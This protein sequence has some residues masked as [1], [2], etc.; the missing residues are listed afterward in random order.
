[1]KKLVVLFN[2]CLMLNL[3]GANA[4]VVNSNSQTLSKI[5]LETGY[6]NNAFS[7]I[8]LYANRVILSEDFIYVVNSGDNSV[9][10]IDLN[11]GETLANIPVENSSNPYDMIIHNGFAFVTG[12]F[13]S[14]VYKID[15]ST[16]QV[17]D[18]IM[19]GNSPEG[20]VVY[21]GKLYVANTNYIY[22][23][24]NPGTVSVIDLNT[25]E[26][27]ETIDVEINPQAFTVADDII[28]L[29]CTGD[30]FSIF[31]KVCIIDPLSNSV[32]ETIEIGGSPANITFAQNGNVYL[33]DGMGIGVYSYNAE[34][35]EII[36]SSQNPFS[37]G[38]SS[39][40][41]NSENIAVVDAGN[42]IENSIV[43]IYDLNEEFLSEYVVAIGA[44]HI[45]IQDEGSSIDE[46][47][48]EIQDNQIYNYPNPFQSETT[49]SFSCHRDTEITEV[50]IYNIKGQQIKTLDCINHVNAKATQLLYSKNWDG[51][52]ESGK[53]VKPGVYFY[54]IKTKDH[55]LISGKMIISR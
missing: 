55:Q 34:T 33:G 19:V 32:M 40:A 51:K 14:K 37:S 23:S 25:F 44:V 18:D 10:K 12:L 28:H 5:D 53:L 17:V 7:V 26:V 16:D 3:F 35:Y 29:V 36:H 9:Q 43:R 22:P 54:Q 15:L 49:I 38:G 4:F 48:P 1:M 8:G 30:Y 11:S 39:I 45:A 50:N 27:I 31:G 21:D 41:A 6:V 47:Y 24:Y 52:D 42:W 46:I 20:M 13:T 2:L